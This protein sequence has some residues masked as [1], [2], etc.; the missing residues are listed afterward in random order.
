MFSIRSSH[1]QGLNN[2]QAND[3][4][5]PGKDGRLAEQDEF[6][7][8]G[9]TARSQLV[10]EVDSSQVMTGMNDL[11]RGGNLQ[12]VPFGNVP[13]GQSQNPA[14]ELQ[15][16]QEEN[17]RLESQIDNLE[18]KEDS[19]KRDTDKEKNRNHRLKDKIKDLEKS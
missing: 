3:E 19:A 1:A 5:S 18:K 4:V 2:T 8:A 15:M 16:L 10:T 12:Q 13:F 7:H 6:E 17:K 9:G 11:T 14:M